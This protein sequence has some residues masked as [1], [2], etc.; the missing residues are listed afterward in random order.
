MPR[1]GRQSASH[2][3]EVLH[4]SPLTQKNMVL[5]ELVFS[6]ENS[7]RKESEKEGPAAPRSGPST[8]PC[9]LGLL[10][11]GG[12]CPG[13]GCRAP[14]AVAARTQSESH[15]CKCKEHRWT[16]GS[17]GVW[18]PGPGQSVSYF[19]FP[20]SHPC[21]MPLLPSP[22]MYSSRPRDASV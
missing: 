10:G 19:P 13:A 8:G 17:V 3:E 14:A 16:R 20:P 9:P 4:F 2:L 21:L 7:Q 22:G 5:R 18:T 1:A 12:N 15:I 11:L 6:T